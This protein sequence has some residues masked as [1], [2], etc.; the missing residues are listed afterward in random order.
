MDISTASG[1]LIIS[2]LRLLHIVAGLIWVGAA[3]LMSFYIEPM[4]GSSGAEGG[5]FLRALYSKTHFPRLIPL[6]ALVATIAGLL[7]YGLLAYHEAMSS[8]MGVI[9]T[10]GALFG[11][12]AFGH[13]Y[14][15]VWRRSGH[16]AR[17]VKAAKADEGTLGQLEDKMRRNGRVSFWLALVS[18]VLMAGARYAGPIFA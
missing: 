10:L 15:T 11:L 18:L 3:L 5:R 6:S 17:L 2:L 4:A 1:A 8:A 12:L 14:F 9:L 16:Y 7:L 13:G